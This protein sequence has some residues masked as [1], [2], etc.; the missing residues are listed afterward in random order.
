[1]ILNGIALRALS[2]NVFIVGLV[3]KA[4]RTCILGPAA[5]VAVLAGRRAEATAPLAADTEEPTVR[6]NEFPFVPSLPACSKATDNSL[7]TG[8]CKNAGRHVDGSL[9][10]LDDR[11]DLNMFGTKDAGTISGMDMLR[12]TNEPTAAA[13]AYGLKTHTLEVRTLTTVL[14]TDA[15]SFSEDKLVPMMWP[16]PFGFSAVGILTG[17]RAVRGSTDSPSQGEWPRSPGRRGGEGG[18]GVG[19]PSLCAC[20]GFLLLLLLLLPP[21][22][23]ALCYFI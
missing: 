3:V 22:H 21:S 8:C 1:M 5:A 11:L 2:P 19:G 6:L 15:A 7:E 20:L 4:S 12:I 18:V 9:P 10:G 23:S 13:V 16:S 17:P 14:W